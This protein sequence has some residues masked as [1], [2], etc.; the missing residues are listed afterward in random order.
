MSIAAGLLVFAG[1]A[2][3]KPAAEPVDLAYILL[4]AAA[5]LI[6]LVALLYGSLHSLRRQQRA[7]A[8]E[9]SDYLRTESGRFLRRKNLIGSFRIDLT[10]DTCHGGSKPFS[11]F[12]SSRYDGPVDPLVER[13]CRLVHPAMQEAFLAQLRR[14]GLLYAFESDTTSVQGDYLFRLEGKG[15]VWLQLRVELVRDPQSGHIQALGYALDIN[16]LKRLEEIGQKLITDDFTRMGLLDAQSGHYLP[17]RTGHEMAGVVPE[18][19]PFRSYENEML[20]DIASLMYP[21]EYQDLAPRLQLAYVRK[22][23]ETQSAYDVTFRTAPREDRPMRYLQIRYRYLSDLHESIVVTSQD[24]SA[25]VATQLDPVTGIY[26]SQGFYQRVEEW[27]RD[28]PGRAYRLLFLDLDDFRYINAAYGYQA[29][30]D[31]LQDIGLYLHEHDTPD[32]FSGHLSGDQFVRFAA[33]GSLTAEQSYALFLK[34]YRR[35]KLGYP[36]QI[37]IGVYD[38]CEPDCDAHAMTYKAQLAQL[39]IRDD[40]SRHIAY[41]RPDMAAANQQSHVLLSEVRTA[42]RD[43]QFRVWFQPQFDYTDGTL[44]GMEA[45]ARWQHPARGMISPAEFIPLL[46]RSNLISRLDRIMWEQACQ[47]LQRWHSMG[48]PVS[49][50][51]NVSRQDLQL[52][53]LCTVFTDLLKRYGITPGLF[54]LEITESVCAENPELMALQAA[55]LRDAGF[56]VEM[57][58]F[59]AGYSSLNTLKDIPADVLKLDMKFLS[60]YR[61]DERSRTVLSATVWMAH[62]LKMKVIAEGVETAQQ[63]DALRRIGCRRMQGYYFA[64]PM[65]PEELEQLLKTARFPAGPD[66]T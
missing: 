34:R 12:P 41:Y 20:P 7:S 6:I 17:F 26:N 42:L 49:V 28:N 58:D 38:L 53:D 50:S 45:L 1:G 24:I 59:G 35:Y 64:K 48:Y 23:L 46:E 18:D 10:E 57:D 32:C 56:V 51:V 33:A 66:E 4:I 47:W 15:Y 29:G 19:A 60:D 52:P 61:D 65:P 13:M 36:L 25:L 40:L 22:M 54:H 5:I 16:R 44:I 30:M 43:R 27:R 9:S 37:H 14:Q 21:R 3:M 31:I 8:R 63:A 2:L 62:A 11:G 55:R 39:S